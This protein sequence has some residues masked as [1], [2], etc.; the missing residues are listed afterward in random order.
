QLAS[1]LAA[2]LEKRLRQRGLALQPV[3]QAATLYV[4]A[5][6]MDAARRHRVADTVRAFNQAHGDD[7]ARPYGPNTN[8]GIPFDILSVVSGPQPYLVLSDGRKLLTG[9]A[10]EGYRLESVEP[11]RLVF[12]SEIADQARE[13]TIDR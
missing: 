5:G 3:W 11:A 7:I 2:D 4:D 1:E 13:T 8:G 6:R 10:V 9:G 12:D